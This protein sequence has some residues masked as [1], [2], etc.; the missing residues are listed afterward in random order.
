LD[1]P[2][3]S[4]L[5]PS[6][7]NF[8][9]TV[10]KNAAEQQLPITQFVVNGPCQC[11]LVVFGARPSMFF[12]SRRCDLSAYYEGKGKIPIMRGWQEL[13]PDGIVGRSKV[14]FSA[15]STFESSIS[16]FI[17]LYCR[18]NSQQF[19][20]QKLSLSQMLCKATYTHL[21]DVRNHAYARLQKLATPREGTGYSSSLR[22]HVLIY[23]AAR[24][25]I[26]F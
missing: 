13:Q 14:R 17:M 18:L 1:T 16:I 7:T 8:A 9:V 23:I 10:T 3:K 5:E 12:Y 26:A 2:A 19:R 15:Y 4:V 25:K 22:I 6:E 24:F 11:L 20:L 21:L